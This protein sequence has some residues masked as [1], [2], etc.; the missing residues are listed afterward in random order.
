MALWRLGTGVR[1]GGSKREG[2]FRG[3]R[4][5]VV[6]RGGVLEVGLGREER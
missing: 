6:V 2:R 1:E 4:M 5:G 3:R